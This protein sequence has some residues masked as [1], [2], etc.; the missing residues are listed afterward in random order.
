ML[1]DG[2]RFIPDFVSYFTLLMIKTMKPT[3][4]IYFTEFYVYY[5]YVS[6]DGWEE[7]IRGIVR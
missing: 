3:Y 6:V 2:V 5:Y 4:R 7:Q 1:Y